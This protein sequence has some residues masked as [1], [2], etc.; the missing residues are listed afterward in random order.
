M[1]QKRV[2]NPNGCSVRLYNPNRFNGMDAGICYVLI[3][4]VFFAL[5]YAMSYF[6]GD[7]LKEVIQYDTLGYSV[8]S[9]TISQTAIFAVALIYC[10]IRRVNPFSGGG[11]KASFDTVHVLMATMLMIGVMM[12]FY[13]THLQFYDYASE[14]VGPTQN[15]EQKISPFTI[16]FAVI[17]FLEVAILPAIA[18]EM[19][20]RGIIMRGLE[21]FGGLFAV[22]CSSAMF[23]LMHGNF[24]QIVLQFIGGLAIGFVVYVTKN[25]L[26]GCI[27]HFVNNAFSVVYTFLITPLFSGPISI[28]IT[29]V[30]GAATIILGVAFCLVGGIY[31]VSMLF[32]KQKNKILNKASSSIYEKKRYY[33]IKIGE[34]E[35]LVPSELVPTLRV[36]RAFDDRLFVINGKYRRIN[37]QSR[38]VASYLVIGI[39]VVLATVMLFLGL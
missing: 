26:L 3:L 33:Q 30:T 23:S 12:L 37:C 34:E 24:G 38:S 21:Q 4:L 27:M 5:P 35:R 9:V 18:E 11:Y 28:K 2:K 17:Y 36:K 20:F 29:A 15:V 14:L 7:F 25:Y 10:L 31:F 13:F 6:I 16:L 32:E 22:I 39:G 1:R 8:I 19:L